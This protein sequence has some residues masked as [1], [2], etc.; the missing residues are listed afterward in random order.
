M[1]Q[2]GRPAADRSDGNDV[3]SPTVASRVLLDI[4]GTQTSI[5]IN[6]V[7]MLVGNR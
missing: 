2:I 3:Q 4:N 5:S 6:F 1:K 7:V